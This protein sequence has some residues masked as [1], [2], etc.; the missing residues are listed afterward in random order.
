M[1]I[2]INESDIR[3]MVGRC[4]SILRE[5]LFTHDDI[6]YS[7]AF[8]L[9]D[10]GIEWYDISDEKVLKV[11]TPDEGTKKKVLS[12]VN[13]YGWQVIKDEGD[14]VTI[15]RK[16]TDSMDNYYDYEAESDQDRGNPDANYDFG[17]GIFYHI[18]PTSN[19]ESILKNGLRP[20]D[21]NKLG[22]ERGRRTYLMTYPD[23][24]LAG[25]LFDR[26]G[27]DLTILKVDLRKYI[28]RQVKTYHDD[29]YD[30]NGSAYTNDYIPPE[31]ISIFREIKSGEHRI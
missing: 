26:D 8:K 1:T 19:V 25:N 20:K 29:L 31:C 23:T 22:Y 28:G 15:E 9:E 2:R 21:N 18:T 5:N 27:S 11:E 3:S 13:Y 24:W 14:S 6:K 30:S 17:V 4:V 7:L 12:L 10:L 16:Y